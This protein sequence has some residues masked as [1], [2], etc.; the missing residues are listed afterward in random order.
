M[1]ILI[2][3]QAGE[4]VFPFKNSGPWE[5]FKKEILS[6]GHEICANGFSERADVVIANSFNKKLSKYMNKMKIPLTGRA[7][8]A[9]EPYVVDCENYKQKNLKQFGYV[10]APSVVWAKK[11][12]AIPFKWPQDA[13]IQEK[14][15]S[16]WKQRKNAIIVIQGN[17]FSAV[18]GEMYSTRRRAIKAFKAD[19]ISLFGTNW[20]KGFAYD[21][22]KWLKSAYDTPFNDLSL[23]SLKGIGSHYKNYEGQIDSKFDVLKN[24]KIALVVE[25]SLDF[26]SEKL[27]DG[28]RAGCIVVY[29]GPNLDLFGLPK[30][31]AIQAS[32]NIN[33]IKET[34][35]KLLLLS[36][37]EQELISN[38]Q[39]TAL[40]GVS[41]YWENTRVLPKL[42]TQIIELLAKRTI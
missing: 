20:N 8:I 30:K 17:K 10:F 7:L 42:A 26:V 36:E 29:V 19:D 24:F 25:N 4:E 12:N 32:P 13:V 38:Q 2:T 41:E 11:M 31:V 37:A 3:G 27:F 9:W 14:V 34:C 16:N 40:V 28:V 5:L 6:Q 35:L 22:H 33:E 21:V 39:T 23:R 18:R 15:S 1:K